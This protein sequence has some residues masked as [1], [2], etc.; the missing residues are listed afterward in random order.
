MRSDGTVELD[1]GTW[2]LSPGIINFPLPPVSLLSH[3][4]SPR[5]CFPAVTHS[6]IP[7]VLFAC[8]P[9]GMVDDQ[10]QAPHSISTPSLPGGSNTGSFQ[11]VTQNTVGATLLRPGF[12]GH[13]GGRGTWQVVRSTYM[14]AKSQTCPNAWEGWHLA[15]PKLKGTQDYML[16][17]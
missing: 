3:S 1:L 12:G 7:E 10:G 6:P 8:E 2:G 15:S 5:L 13:S 11:E 9:Q 17:D 14:H 16:A 4:R